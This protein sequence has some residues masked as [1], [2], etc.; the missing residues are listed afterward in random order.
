MATILR[1]KDVPPTHRLGELQRLMSRFDFAASRFYKRH[2]RPVLD[3]YGTV[4]DVDVDRV[5]WDPE[6]PIETTD[7]TPL[8]LRATGSGLPQRRATPEDATSED[9]EPVTQ[10]EKPAEATAPPKQTPAVTPRPA[11]MQVINKPPPGEEDFV[12]SLVEKLKAEASLVTPASPPTTDDVAGIVGKLKADD[13]DRRHDHEYRG[14]RQPPIGIRLEHVVSFLGDQDVDRCI[15]W[16]QDFAEVEE[17]LRFV[18]TDPQFRGIGKFTRHLL[19]QAKQMVEAHQ[20]FER[21]H[22]P[23]DKVRL[24]LVS[25][26]PKPRPRLQP[27]GRRPLVLA[28]ESGVQFPRIV[29]HKTPQLVNNQCLGWEDKDHNDFLDLLAKDEDEMWRGRNTKATLLGKNNLAS[30]EEELFQETLRKQT[31]G[32]AENSRTGARYLPDGRVVIES[33]ECFAQERGVRRAGIQQCLQ[34]IDNSQ[35]TAAISPFNR[36]VLPTTARQLRQAQKEAAGVQYRP[37]GLKEESLPQTGLESHPYTTCF[38]EFRLAREAALEETRKLLEKEKEADADSLPLPPTIDLLFWEPK[39]NLQEGRD[40][41]LHRDMGVV[42]QLLQRAKAVAPRKLLDEIE[43]HMREGMAG[44]GW[45][46][47]GERT[48]FKFKSR[49]SDWDDAG[50]R[51]KLRLLNKTELFWLR[52]LMTGSVNQKLTEDL[53]HEGH[54]MFLV[55]VQ[56]LQRIFDTFNDHPDRLFRTVDEGVPVELLLKAM[57]QGAGYPVASAR[58]R[59]SLYDAMCWLDRLSQHGRCR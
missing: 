32:V 57:N 27:V 14:Q 50:G 24:P 33:P 58:T 46:R 1:T 11:T 12:E 47:D 40:E 41:A 7:W 39:Q 19:E 16:A 42:W 59:W 18:D 4:I 28:T 26:I 5:G 36:V 49:D 22:A 43:D 17:Y 13:A 55:F 6:E 54:T 10:R 15:S 52:F 48:R 3:S 29:L 45:V 30:L 31:G 25:E 44:T 37:L 20:V 8:S 9:G 51:R 34:S 53:P 56:R 23:M 21:R 35:A 38:A 2:V